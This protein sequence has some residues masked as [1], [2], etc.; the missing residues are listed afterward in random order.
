ME[1]AVTFTTKGGMLN[2]VGVSDVGSATGLE[3]FKAVSGVR[4]WSEK[5]LEE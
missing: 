3:D 1:G 2:S 4:W 5:G